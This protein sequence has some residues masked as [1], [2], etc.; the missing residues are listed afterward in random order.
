MC[1][2]RKTTLV[3]ILF[4]LVLALANCQGNEK[5]YD[6]SSI[7][8]LEKSAS[9]I[10]Q[11]MTISQKRELHD[12]ISNIAISQL[13]A[14]DIMSN[15]YNKEAANEKLLKALD[16]KTAKQVI[17]ESKRITDEREA[18][19][20]RSAIRTIKQLE[21]KERQAELDKIKL[22]KFVIVNSKFYKIS[23]GGTAKV[24]PVIEFTVRNETGHTISKAYFNIIIESPGKKT[25]WFTTNTYHIFP[26][27]LNPGEEVSWKLLPGSTSYW[28]KV[29]A[30][31]DATM[32]VMTYELEGPKG[33]QLYS[34]KGLSEYEQGLLEEYKDKYLEQE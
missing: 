4:L 14:N 10:E 25:P 9:V 34:S 13:T 27:N 15:S 24:Q 2:V 5:T 19:I 3:S 11:N 20:R 32:K 30:P 1:N 12:A 6:G 21:E 29:N 17:E 16:G 28:W 8:A 33:N 7:G 18:V 23:S 31:D 26:R 22:K